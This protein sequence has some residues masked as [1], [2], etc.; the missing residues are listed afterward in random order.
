MLDD[1]LNQPGQEV[2]IE[3]ILGEAL[4]IP[5]LGAV[6]GKALQ[7]DQGDR[8]AGSLPS[9]IKAAAKRQALDL[10][11][12]WKASVAL[13]LVASWAEKG[14]TLADEV[15]DNAALL[16]SVLNESFENMDSRC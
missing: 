7:L 6:L 15:L 3:D 9:Q 13:H 4:I 2:E 16:F 11:E 5:G 8:S 14:T 12:G 1:V 10:P